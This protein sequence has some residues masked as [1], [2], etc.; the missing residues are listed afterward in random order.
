MLHLK[1][2][3]NYLVVK[4]LSE[5]QGRVRQRR[6]SEGIKIM[7]YLFTNFIRL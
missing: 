3:E 6:A 7:N 2:Q 1:I 4:T 5:H